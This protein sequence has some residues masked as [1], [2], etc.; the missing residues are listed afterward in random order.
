[1]YDWVFIRG[2][3][4]FGFTVSFL[5][6]NFLFVIFVIYVFQH[7]IIFN[8]AEFYNMEVEEIQELACFKKRSKQVK[9]LASEGKVGKP[10]ISC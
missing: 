1:M 10:T 6:D 2:F 8:C 5:P 9:H 7:K 4:L 3:K